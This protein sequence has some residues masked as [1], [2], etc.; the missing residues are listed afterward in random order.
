MFILVYVDVIIA[1]SSN[2]KATSVLLK[3]LGD[4]SALKDLRDLHYFPGI[5]VNKVKDGI[6]LSQDK[7]DVDLLKRVGM[8][9]CKP[10]N[11]PLATSEK[12]SAQHKY[13]WCT[14]VFNSN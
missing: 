5:A 8:S 4:D 9:A 1:T 7:H 10:V 14:L 2:P 3:K 12:L 13:C 11:T 6:I